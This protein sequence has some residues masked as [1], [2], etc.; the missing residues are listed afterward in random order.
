MIET[1]CLCI[2]RDGIDPPLL[3]CKRSTLPL[4]KRGKKDS[5]K[6]RLTISPK[7]GF[8]LYQSRDIGVPDFRFIVN[9]VRRVGVEP[10]STN[11]VSTVYKTATIP[12]HNL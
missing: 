9:L 3:R 6:D 8:S 5:L 4:C 12:A 1:S 2:P 7:I 11:Y 10:T